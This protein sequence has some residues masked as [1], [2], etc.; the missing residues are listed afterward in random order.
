MPDV[1]NSEWDPMAEKQCWS[2]L[3]YE[4][5]QSFEEPEHD[6]KIQLV[7]RAFALVHVRS[8]EPVTHC[9][10]ELGGWATTI[11]R[12]DDQGNRIMVQ[13]RQPLVFECAAPLAAPRQV[14]QIADN[15]FSA[16]GSQELRRALETE[17]N[18]SPTPP[19]FK[20]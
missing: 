7:V 4:E 14:V 2:K 13:R 12:T 18:T 1:A 8:E 15:W 9:V 20:Q 16:R 11:E 3:I 6:C 10:V 17:I 5:R 19:K